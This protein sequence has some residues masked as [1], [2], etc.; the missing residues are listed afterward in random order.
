MIGFAGFFVS[1]QHAPV[2]AVTVIYYSYPIVVVGLFALVWKRRLRFWEVAVCA[3]VLAGV[4]LAVGPI[5][6][7]PQLALALA[8]AVAAPAGWAIYLVILSGPAAAMPTLPKIFAGTVGGVAALLPIALVVTRGRLLPMT[9]DAVTSMAWLTLCTLAI[10]VVLV[11][12]GSARAGERTTAMIGS[13]EFVVAVTTG[14]LLMG[15]HLSPVQV[16]GAT[17]V[18]CAALYAARQSSNDTADTP[19]PSHA[20]PTDTYAKHPTSRNE[21]ATTSR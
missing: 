15:Q 5:G 13:F 7:S 19:A 9:G 12:W 21:P 11:T 17:L 2:A 20:H 3:T 1:L 10:P 18:V 4:I 8:P 6:L 16:L 14:W